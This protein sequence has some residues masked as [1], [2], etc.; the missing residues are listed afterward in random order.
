MN[1]LLYPFFLIELSCVKHL[2]IFLVLYRALT[3]QTKAIRRDCSWYDIYHTQSRSTRGGFL[4]N[5]SRAGHDLGTH[6]M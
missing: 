1:L 2:D 6:F 4:K 5:R 3:L